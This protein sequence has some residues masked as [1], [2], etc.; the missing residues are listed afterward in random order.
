MWTH[1][2]GRKSLVTGVSADHIEGMDWAEGRALL[3]KLDATITSDEYV[4]SH[5]WTVGDLL[6][7]DNTVSLHR[8][9]HYEPTSGRLMHRVTLE[10]EESLA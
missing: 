8:A 1:K 10:G 9:A 7:W 4:Y 3:E 2:S 6:I 5:E